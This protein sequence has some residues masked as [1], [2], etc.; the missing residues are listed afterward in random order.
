[1]DGFVDDTTVWTN[2]FLKS[3][4]GGTSATESS[5]KLGQA[6]QWWEQLL[7]STGGKLE[8]EK[9]FYY[10]FSW[11]FEEDGRARLATKE[12][13]GINITVEQSDD[14][15]AQKITQLDNDEWHQ[16]LGVRLNPL[17]D[18]VKGEYEHLLRK[19]QELGMA[20]NGKAVSRTDAYIYH[21]SMVLPSLSYSLPATTLT[22]R[23]LEQIQ[24][25]PFRASIRAQGYNPHMP[26]TVVF[27]DRKTWEA[28]VSPLYTTCKEL[29]TL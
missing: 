4:Q 16:T 21:T 15:S 20:I 7:Y 26:Q 28:W 29:S 6:A 27:G 12:E 17:L 23:Q 3:L 11:I 9:C 8:L 22:K 19:G 14:G 18:N 24:A 1:M 2:D 25:V 5:E 13:L 10:L